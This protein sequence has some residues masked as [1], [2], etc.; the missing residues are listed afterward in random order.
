MEGC[1]LA[2][3]TKVE[4]RQHLQLESEV[5]SGLV[6]SPGDRENGG[7]KAFIFCG[8]IGMTVVLAVVEPAEARF[9]SRNE[10]GFR[11]TSNANYDSTDTNSDFYYQLTSSNSFFT[12]H[13]HFGVRLSYSDYL[14][15]HENDVAKW[16]LSDW[17]SPEGSAWSYYV[18]LSGQ[19]YTNEA[20]G[21]TDNS[22]NNVGTELGAERS[23]EMSEKTEW[24]LFPG[25]Q[26]K[27]YS[28]AGGRTDHKI[29]TTAGIQHELNNKTKLGGRTEIGWQVS[30]QD[31]YN[32]LYLV[33]GGDHEYAFGSGWSWLGDLSLQRTLF[34]RRYI[35]QA[36]TSS[37]RRGQRVTSTVQSRETYSSVDLS[38]FV[39][40]Q[41]SAVTQANAGLAFSNQSSASGLQDYSVMEIRANWL[42]IF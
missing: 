31:D 3:W 42:L 26:F 22:F 5:E 17:C 13:H 19:Q 29:Y 38:A 2:Y 37:I 16:K 25:Y 35:N 28:N 40:K 41:I 20:P 23:Y 33:V 32:N 15:Q 9:R 27:T 14:T 12:D 11:S 30:N 6:G 21:S 7:M 24:T 8:I 34:T 18:A 4:S 10:V 1:P 36:T 39:K